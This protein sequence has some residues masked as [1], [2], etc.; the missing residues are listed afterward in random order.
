MKLGG[1]MKLQARG[2]YGCSF[3]STGIWM[4]VQVDRHIDE[5]SYR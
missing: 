2:A 4:K 3:K 1:H 5:A